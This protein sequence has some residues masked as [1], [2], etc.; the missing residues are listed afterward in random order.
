MFFVFP[1]SLS[2]S[3]QSVNS[4]KHFIVVSS[5]LVLIVSCRTCPHGHHYFL[6]RPVADLHVDRLSPSLHAP[7]SVRQWSCRSSSTRQLV[8][9]SKTCNTWLLPYLGTRLSKTCVTQQRKHG[10]RSTE[11]WRQPILS[12]HRSRTR[13]FSNFA[14]TETE[15]CS[16]PTEAIHEFFP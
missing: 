6:H 12:I 10:K 4:F 14:S 11:Y 2:I 8:I 3:F 5:F 1:P 9:L 16:C 7:T 15:S 13:F